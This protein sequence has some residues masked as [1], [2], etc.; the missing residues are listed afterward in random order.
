MSYPDNTGW[1]IESVGADMWTS[2]FGDGQCDAV[3]NLVDNNTGRSVQLIQTYSVQFEHTWND[4]TNDS[5]RGMSLDEA[6]ETYNE[7]VKLTEE[8]D[9]VKRGYWLYVSSEQWDAIN[10]NGDIYCGEIEESDDNS[11]WK[12]LDY[13][14][15]AEGGKEFDAVVEDTIK[16]I[17]RNDAERTLTFCD[18]EEIYVK[19]IREGGP[20]EV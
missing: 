6:D 9:E 11:W 8:G 1:T 19:T 17:T 10:A 18:M 5:H 16:S 7:I 4:E 20:L 3:A 13:D 15:P 14:G 2:G 12:N